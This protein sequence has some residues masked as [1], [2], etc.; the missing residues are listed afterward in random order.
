MLVRIR[1]KAERVAPVSRFR[2]AALATA[3]LLAPSA[4]V[5]F[6]V[7]FW[8]LAAG[9]EWTS[10]FFV[11]HGLFAHWQVWMAGAAILLLLSRLLNAY[12]QGAGTSNAESSY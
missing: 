1:I 3:S 9:F 5:A 6:A 8:G 10:G 2:N 11:S 4:L 12:A 7:S